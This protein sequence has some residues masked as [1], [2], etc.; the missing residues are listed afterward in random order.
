VSGEG[1]GTAPVP[2]GRRGGRRVEPVPVREPREGFTAVGVV[3]KA[4]GVRGEVRVRGFSVEAPHLQRGRWV[5]VEGL[6]RR[7]RGS[8]WD[9]DMWLLSLSGVDSREEAEALRGALLEVP[10]AE[11]EREDEESYFLHELIGLRVVT[12]DRRELGVLKEVLQPGANDVYVVES[13]EGELLL[14]AIGEVVERVDVAG[15]VVVV[16]LPE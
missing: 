5:W 6:R 3:V 9:R 15:G 1:G 14:P 7:V 8:R 10:D 11:V 4:H 2:R 12:V 13:P 16:R